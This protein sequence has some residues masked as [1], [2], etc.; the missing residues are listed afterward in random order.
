MCQNTN[1][2]GQE[3][4]NE[5]YMCGF[6]LKPEEKIHRIVIIQVNMAELPEVSV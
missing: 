1:R 5:T 2:P 3:A 6:E 4:M